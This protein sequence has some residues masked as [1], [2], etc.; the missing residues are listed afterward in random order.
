MLDASDDVASGLGGVALLALW[1]VGTVALLPAERGYVAPE[2]KAT[3]FS[4]FVLLFSELVGTGILSLPFA[5]SVL[6]WIPG[7][8]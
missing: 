1:G 7:V 5:L 2:R 8:W 3:W 4:A 6:G